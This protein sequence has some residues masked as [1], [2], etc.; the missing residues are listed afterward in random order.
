MIIRIRRTE[1]ETH[2]IYNADHT[3]KEE[4]SEPHFRLECRRG[5]GSWDYLSSGNAES[6]LRAIKP[7]LIAPVILDTSKMNLVVAEE[8]LK[9][10]TETAP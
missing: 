9:R 8:A 10:L 2:R 4:V 3:F 5:W 6:I 1:D 7:L